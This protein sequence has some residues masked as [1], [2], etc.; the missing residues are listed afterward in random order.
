MNLP[1]SHL[2]FCT[3]GLQDC[4]FRCEH[5]L[6]SFLR[7]TQQNDLK[8]WLDFKREPRQPPCRPVPA[9]IP[10]EWDDRRD[11][12]ACARWRTAPSIA[13]SCC[14]VE[15]SIGSKAIKVTSTLVSWYTSKSGCS[16]QNVD[17]CKP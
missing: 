10:R 17:C 14:S 3:H 9:A 5:V 4:S 8:P 2:R 15:R 6:N 12:L 11:V 13:S 7:Q 16:D 1:C